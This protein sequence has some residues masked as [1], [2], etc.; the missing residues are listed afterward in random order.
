MRVSWTRYTGTWE[1]RVGR[2]CL[3]WKVCIVNALKVTNVRVNIS[4]DHDRIHC[5]LFYYLVVISSVSL[6]LQDAPLAFAQSCALRK[7]AAT[8]QMSCWPDDRFILLFWEILLDHC[9]GSRDFV[10]PSVTMGR[11]H[12][13]KLTEQSSKKL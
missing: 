4:H 12:K 8:F 11:L 1:N 3:R 13:A 6:L 9:G 2:E 5:R 7:A 10:Y